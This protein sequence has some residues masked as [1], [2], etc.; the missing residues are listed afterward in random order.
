LP[1][2]A[3]SAC[4]SGVNLEDGSGA[5][6]LPYAKIEAAKRGAAVLRALVPAT[7]RSTTRIC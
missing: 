4:D 7:R 6:G 3:L 1:P 5:P 2:P